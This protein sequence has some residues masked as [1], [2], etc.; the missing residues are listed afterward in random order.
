MS[1]YVHLHVAFNANGNDG[2]AALAKQHL[3][4]MEKQAK[5]DTDCSINDDAI[6][7][8]QDMSKRTGPN[9]GPKGGLCLWGIVGNYVRPEDFVEVLKPFW[10]DLL[11]ED[12]KDGPLNHHHIIVFYEHQWSEQAKALEI[13]VEAKYNESG[14]IEDTICIKKHEDLPFTWMQSC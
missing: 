5:D 3:A 12:I 11:C 1:Y 7:F 9:P 2:I 6:S 4:E 14:Y 13:Y 8:L 10:L